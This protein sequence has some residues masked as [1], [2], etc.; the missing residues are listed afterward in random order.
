MSDTTP[1]PDRRPVL[2]RAL[3]EFLDAGAD[4]SAT[5]LPD[6]SVL[7][8]DVPAGRPDDNPDDSYGTATE[9]LAL[10]C[11]PTRRVHVQVTR[12]VGAAEPSP[13]V[14][15]LPGL[16]WSLGDA[17]CYAQLVRE[18]ALGTDAAVVYVDYTRAPAARYPVAVEQCHAVA[19][20]IHAH[21][22]EVGLEG[23][24]IAAVGD[25]A[26]ANLVAALTLLARERGDV[27]L[28]HQ[29]L[30][31]PVTDADFDTPSYHRFA[32]GY[33]L[34]RDHMRWFWDDYLPERQ[35]RSEATAAP[36]RASLDQLAGLPP[37]LVITAEA[38]VL[39]DEGEAYAARLR[40]AGVPVV[41]MRYQGAVHGF[42]LLDALCPTAT[43][44]AALIQVV[45]TV[46][47]ALHRRSW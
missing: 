12:P 19:R 24:R 10:P 47:V 2:D 3:Q 40:A 4:R 15:F 13:V 5:D 44:R 20:W 23:Q 30:L 42:L 36:L 8:S 45:D 28:V 43:A 16:G 35:R 46:H 29:V 17:A 39:R 9:W 34:H 25:S 31:C 14:L 27:R 1:L 7:T 32:T 11:G 26:G 6:L 41:A 21:G 22:H 37:A 33:F 18:F 38:D